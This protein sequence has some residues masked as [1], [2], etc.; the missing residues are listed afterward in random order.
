MARLVY[1]QSN[2][3]LYAVPDEVAAAA[4]SGAMQ[5]GAAYSGHGLGLNNPAMQNVPDVGPLPQ[6]TYVIGDPHD[7]MH[8][9]PSR[10]TLRRTRQIRCSA[11]S[12]SVSTATTRK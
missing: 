9:V 3:I 1:S 12:L 4:V 10:S 11:A 6:G 2:G 8:T 7:N 5:I